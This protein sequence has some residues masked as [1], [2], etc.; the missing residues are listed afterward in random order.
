M[1]TR[2]YISRGRLQGGNEGGRLIAFDTQKF[3]LRAQSHRQC[4]PAMA[5]RAP[6]AGS[7]VSLKWTT[8]F[9][10]SPRVAIVTNSSAAIL[11]GKSSTR[12]LAS[13]SGRSIKSYPKK[14]K[15]EKKAQGSSGDEAAAAWRNVAPLVKQLEE[16]GRI[17]LNSEE[18]F[19]NIPDW[20]WRF[21][22]KRLCESKKTDIACLLLKWL[23]H[24]NRFSGSSDIPFSIVVNG[25]GKEGRLNDAF[26]LVE[27]LKTDVVW[28]PTA[29]ANSLIEAC[30]RNGEIEKSLELLERMRKHGMQPD[31]VTYSIIIQGCTKAKLELTTML[32]VYEQMQN[33]RLEIDGKLYNDMI[34]A[35]AVGNDPDRAFF[36]MEKLQAGGYVP[37]MKS[38]MSLIQVLGQSGRTTEAEAVF[39]EMKVSGFVPNTRAYN[40][41]LAA[42]ARK[43]MMKQAEQIVTAIKEA[44]LYLNERSYGLLIDAYAR[45]GRLE[46]AMNIFRGMKDAGMK[47]NAF[48]YS[49]MMSMF[50]DTGQWEGSILMLREMQEEGIPPN[51]HVYNILIDT[52]GKNGQAEAARKVFDKMKSENIERDVVTW[53]SLIEACCKAEK[54]SEVPELYR[55]MQEDGHPPS[56]H[57]F[58]IIIN[59]F[60]AQGD[61]DMVEKFLQ[62][63]QILGIVRNEVTYTTLVDL[64]GR[65]GRFQEAV[66]WLEDMKAS[67]MKPGSA[68]F[69]ALANAYAQEDEM[70][71]DMLRSALRFSEERQRNLESVPIRGGDPLEA[72]VVFGE[73][74]QSNLC[75]QLQTFEGQP[76]I[77]SAAT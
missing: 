38:F 43:G 5:L 47:P 36:F 21:G 67:G 62:E 22:L 32:K 53:N 31:N 13:W 70:A 54:F 11:D 73:G 19:Q 57:T 56:A 46:Q 4:T 12:E 59:H 52:Y 37:E 75:V 69:C 3:C 68:V 8:P 35:S 72:K 49:R 77:W 40:A 71:R 6:C 27:L 34:V 50:R 9:S 18:S 2:V 25:L 39:E 48:I 29:T 55:K 33:E 42:F 74:F 26:L 20:Q 51:K 23:H 30:S 66:D 7:L 64:Y 28:L 14:W 61:W 60:G 65:S 44:G 45:A 10:F 76:A 58:N 24:E 41:L 63:M 1:Q 15:N 17:Q 16:E